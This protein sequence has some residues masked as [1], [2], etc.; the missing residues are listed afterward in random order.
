MVG[1]ED[2]MTCTKRDQVSESSNSD[3]EDPREVTENDLAMVLVD[4]LARG[5]Q[6]VT[7]K[8]GKKE[9]ISDFYVT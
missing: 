8:T 4:H 1:K 9:K 6:K 5:W 3:K 2:G 7:R